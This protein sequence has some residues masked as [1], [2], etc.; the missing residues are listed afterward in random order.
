MTVLS[1]EWRHLAAL[2]I[3]AAIPA[4]SIAAT[5]PDDGFRDGIELPTLAQPTQEVQGAYDN[6]LTA[7][8][9]F[10]SGTPATNTYATCGGCYAWSSTFY[11]SP[12]NFDLTA[13]AITVPAGSMATAFR[14]WW[15]YGDDGPHPNNANQGGEAVDFSSI[16]V[17]LYDATGPGGAPGGLLANLAGTW[18][19][20]DAGTHYREYQLATPYTFT[21]TSYYVSVRAVTSQTN[22]GAT[23]LM[24]MCAPS[25]ALIDYENYLTSAGNTGGWSLYTGLNPCPADQNF[26]CQVLGFLSPTEVVMSPEPGC[27]TDSDPCKTVTF[28]LQRT[29]ATPARA[30][31]VTFTLSS[32]LALC[33]G[34]ASIVEED[35]LS[36]YCGGLCTHFEKHLT[37]TKTYTVDCAILG[38]D[39]G[40]TG[41][42]T[43]FTI[44]VARDASDGVGTITITSILLRDCVNGPIPVVAGTPA[45]ITVDTV[46][47]LAASSLGAVQVKSG[48]DS[49]GTTKITVSYAGGDA[50]TEIYRAPYGTGDVVGAYPEYD[51]VGGAGAPATPTYAQAQ[52]APWALTTVTA[53]GQADEPPVRGLWYYVA[54]NKDACGNISPASSLTGGTLNYH[55]GDVTDGVTLGQGDNLVEAVDISLLGDNYGISLIFNDPVNY[56]DVGPTTDYSV[57]GRPTTD[58]LVD[59]EDLLMFAIN[60][61]EVGFQ[62]DTPELVALGDAPASAGPVR[63]ELGPSTQLARAG[64]V[65][66]VPVMLRGAASDVQ[67]IGTVLRYD[68]MALR[69]ESSRVSDR[70]ES[71]EHFFK[72]L[73]TEGQVDLSLALLGH[74]AA[75]Q[76]E[77]AVMVV[78]MRALRT[79]PLAMDLTES[80]VRDTA[81]RELLA[82]EG[83]L[84][85]ATEEPATTKVLSYRLEA[86]PNPFN[87]RTTITYELPEAAEVHLVIVDVAGR[88]VRTLVEEMRPAG[89]YA[90]E[91][92]GRDDGGRPAGS[93]I[94]F[95]SMRAGATEFQ[96]RLTLLK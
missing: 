35:F 22:Y 48:N 54:F 76:G 51:D 26:G 21:G 63:L 12:A 31:S 24:L 5:A 46:P 56:L 78:R 7:L 1:R 70:L 65:I 45:S 23:L 87:P 66:E 96:K 4:V 74:G 83:T 89:S 85:P 84:R 41:N 28:S 60:Y 30:Y 71:S 25:D 80:R 67:G 88:V 64:Q 2:L 10:N 95:T 94:Y 53:S 14:F 13:R 11:S 42:G 36:D 32:E 77:G 82:H 57:D 61:E 40:P 47:P 34:L 93:G 90:V 3:L 18:T 20:L 9:L 86:H 81:N 52:L 72:D 37:G 59:F 33:S 79:G 29:D 62:G 6:L 17:D 15:A 8:Y 19:V 73:A 16:T 58:N 75:M 50:T 69:Y 27:L 44:D 55:L 91:W 92:D 68:P 49:N 43:L 39:C 38:G